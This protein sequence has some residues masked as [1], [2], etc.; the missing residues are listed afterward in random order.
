MGV[1]LKLGVAGALSLSA[2]ALTCGTACLLHVPPLHGWMMAHHCPLAMSGMKRV[3]SMT[4]SDEPTGMFA[5]DDRRMN[6]LGP[7]PTSE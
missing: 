6:V 1:A 3:P 2:A 4:M 7:H 5:G